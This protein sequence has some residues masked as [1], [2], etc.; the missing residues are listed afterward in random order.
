MD[1]NE[2]IIEQIR[3]GKIDIN[4]QQLFFSILL[5]GLMM[6]LKQDITI[7]DYPVP[8]IITH[9]GKDWMYLENKGYDN[10]QE[11]LTVTNEDYIYNAIP[12]CNVSPGGI[13]LIPDQLT[14]PYTLGML[15]FETDDAVY[16][17]YSEFRRMPLKL[18]VELKYV[19]DSFRDHLELVQQIITK[20][21]FIRTFKIIY[22][23]QEIQCSYRIPESF[24]GEHLT[25][26]DGMTTDAKQHTLQLSIEVETN[27]PIYSPQT[28]ISADSYISGF[29]AG[30]KDKKIE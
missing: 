20:L 4:N 11:P 10:S 19:T 23:G 17:L 2:N 28:I 18:G 24:S 13:D 16:S 21:T 27:L 12:R 5:K 15:Q 3:Q 9:T 6:K 8:H 22:M 14:N 26:M 7:R 25:E 29:S 30:I 1:K